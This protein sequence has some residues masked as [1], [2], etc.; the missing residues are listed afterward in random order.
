MDL[1][2]QKSRKIRSS[3]FTYLKRNFFLDTLWLSIFVNH[4]WSFCNRSARITLATMTVSMAAVSN[5]MFYKDEIG[6]QVEIGP[7]RFSPSIL[8]VNFITSI[9]TAVPA[10]IFTIVFNNTAPKSLAHVQSLDVWKYSRVIRPLGFIACT[11]ISMIS[12][13]FA[14]L[15]ALMME[16]S[17]VQNWVGA[18]LFAN[19]CDITIAPILIILTKSIINY[20]FNFDLNKGHLSYF[21]H[22]QRTDLMRKI[23]NESPLQALDN[24][25]RLPNDI[26]QRDDNK[27]AKVARRQRHEMKKTI[28]FTLGTILMTTC[29]FII[30]QT[31]LPSEKYWIGLTYR[32]QLPVDK[33]VE[34]SGIWSFID[35]YIVNMNFPSDHDNGEP[36][37]STERKM[38][39]D[40]VNF[41]VG[42]ARLFQL[43]H[44]CDYYASEWVVKN[45]SNIAAVEYE[46]PL[47]QPWF[48]LDHSNIPRDWRA[49]TVPSFGDCHYEAE[50]GNTRK[51]SI[52]IID[53]LKEGAWI[54]NQTTLL[55]FE[56]TFFNGNTNSFSQ[57]R[58]SFEH[59]N[60]GAFHSQLRINQFQYE[61]END[62]NLYFYAYCFF[63]VQYAFNFGKLINYILKKKI[64]SKS[65]ATL[66]FLI[67]D[68]ILAY[69]VIHKI[70][71]TAIAVE[72]FQLSPRSRPPFDEL[73][74]YQSS[75]VS[76]I[77][78][79]LYCHTLHLIVVFASVNMVK[80]K[81]IQQIRLT[82]NGSSE[83]C[84]LV[85]NNQAV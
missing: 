50:L 22:E 61:H 40:N 74:Y 42:P 53:S 60:G 66:V 5:L 72:Q 63:V 75:A 68:T 7:L 62:S 1:I 41:R 81:S 44:V 21:I 31:I 79:V 27:V 28:Q 10:F 45:K 59:V 17:Q 3:P 70:I 25:V 83:M 55:F 13:F 65:M 54:D 34:V 33:M 57:V 43:R 4:P 30:S 11:M 46:S 56:Q 2:Q 37:S 6:P 82:K 78:V 67:F 52:T 76:T 12:F 49:D 73:F 38:S 36:L 19:I 85:E 48:V 47:R 35:E 84:F 39:G 14:I 32:E 58:L 18:Q 77:A 69:N 9:M 8:Y 64:S 51:T 29:Y 71:E 15:Y 26:K 16:K 24:I 23:Y 20:F 80:S